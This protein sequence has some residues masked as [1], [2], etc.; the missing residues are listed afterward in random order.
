MVGRA[1]G[2]GGGAFCTVVVINWNGG[3][4]LLQCIESLK[5]Q[6]TGGLEIL[7][8]DNG[9]TD[10]SPEQ[11][12]ELLQG[13]GPT[14]RLVR[15]DRNVGFAPA[16]AAAAGMC[17]R[18]LLA[19]VNS[20]V[21]LKPNWLQNLLAAL[22]QN[23]EAGSA[24]GKV[25]FYHHPEVIES[26]GIQV[27][28]AGVATGRD[29]G[30][31]ASSRNGPGTVLGAPGCAAVYRREALI[32]S[33]GFDPDYF[34]YLEDVDLAIRL[35][36]HGHPCLYV[37]EAVAL[38]RHSYSSTR[39]STFNKGVLLGRNRIWM[40]LTHL[41]TKELLA[42]LWPIARYDALA[43]V[44]SLLAR[45]D[46]APLLGRLWGLATA[47]KPLSKRPRDGGDGPA[48]GGRT[49][50]WLAWEDPAAPLLAVLRRRGVVERMS[51]EE[52]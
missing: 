33:G 52:G 11:A 49:R 7:L 18:P 40:L 8:W 17:T 1:A 5:A 6:T 48:H 15:N 46:P 19:A 39:R 50:P 41:G 32:R 13:P 34:M 43:S 28:R 4:V 2:T 16:M 51:R 37:P 38:H 12:A 31:P 25:V 10:G 26:T 23:P 35:L 21:V 44:F 45:R 24:C 27:D 42:R 3:S 22:K 30:L 9:S 14:L 47:F 36:N 29:L 20:D